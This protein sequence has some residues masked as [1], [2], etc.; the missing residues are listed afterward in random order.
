MLD[1]PALFSVSG[2]TFGPTFYLFMKV[3]KRSN[4]CRLSDW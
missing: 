1:F 2:H 4:A 3:M